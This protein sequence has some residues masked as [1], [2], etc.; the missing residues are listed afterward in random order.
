MNCI[1]CDMDENIKEKQEASYLQSWWVQKPGCEHPNLDSTRV[2]WPVCELHRKFSDVEECYPT[3]DI[4]GMKVV[5]DF[6]RAYFGDC[7]ALPGMEN[8]GEY[9]VPLLNDALLIK[10]VGISYRRFRADGDMRDFIDT[11]DP[12]E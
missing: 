5:V 10:L 3:Y 1:V 11:Y 7:M 2:Y 12:T 9:Q 8:D 6:I 4:Q